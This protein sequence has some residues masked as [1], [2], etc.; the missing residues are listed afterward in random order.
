VAPLHDPTDYDLAKYLINRGTLQGAY[1]TVREAPYVLTKRWKRET[2][3]PRCVIG[4][5]FSSIAWNTD[6]S[7]AWSW[8]LDPRQFPRFHVPPFTRDLAVWRNGYY[9][10]WNAL[11]T[12]RLR[13]L[14][15]ALTLAQERGWRVIGFAPPE[16]P[17]YLR[18]LDTDPGLATQWH[19]FVRLMPSL[20]R[21]HGF[22]WTPLW[23]GAA[24]GCRPGNY[25][26]AFHSDASCSARL[27][28]ALDALAGR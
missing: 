9:A 3:G 1:K 5:T 7:R 10:G 16:P 22:A 8:E 21:R 19:A 25:P 14:D 18:L 2:I 23:D 15:G 13:A 24:L 12:G 26:D 28:R 11:D 20:F 27:R 6:G 4:C 17:G